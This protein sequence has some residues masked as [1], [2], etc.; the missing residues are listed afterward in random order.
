LKAPTST[1]A[2]A[3]SRSFAAIARRARPA[4]EDTSASDTSAT[5]TTSTQTIDAYIAPAGYPPPIFSFGTPIR[6]IWPPVTPSQVKTSER[7]IRCTAS[8]AKAR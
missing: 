3:A 4:R 6:P 2:A 7:K 1:P 5:A 8:V